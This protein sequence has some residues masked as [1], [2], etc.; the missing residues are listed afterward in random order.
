MMKVFL[1]GTVEDISTFF[2]K[3]QGTVVKTKE[4]EERELEE[5]KEAMKRR[6]GSSSK[7]QDDAANVDTNADGLSAQ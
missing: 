2:A 7:K 4:E 5:F 3:V 1:E 6:Y